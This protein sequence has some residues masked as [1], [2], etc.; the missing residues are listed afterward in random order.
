M[1][2]MAVREPSAFCMPRGVQ[3]QMRVETRIPIEL[4]RAFSELAQIVQIS[5]ERNPATLPHQNIVHDKISYA[6]R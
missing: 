5:R 3:L 2:G 1:R 4:A 6:P